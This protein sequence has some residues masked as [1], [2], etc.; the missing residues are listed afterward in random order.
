[1]F[2]NKLKICGK[3]NKEG[4][5]RTDSKVFFTLNTRINNNDKYKS[6]VYVEFNKNIWDKISPDDYNKELIIS[7]EIQARKTKNNSPFIYLKTHDV[8]LKSD[9]SKKNKKRINKQEKFNKTAIKWTH[10]F[11]EEEFEMIDIS[12]VY[13]KE[14]EHM[15]GVIN[16]YTKTHK[17]TRDRVHGKVVVKSEEDGR[18]SL[19]AGFTEF[20]HC[21]LLDLDINAYVTDLSMEEFKDKYF[22]K[23]VEEIENETENE[24]NSETDGLEEES[25]EIVDETQNNQEES[26]NIEN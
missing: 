26:V 2:S 24:T 1:M 18:Y 23:T 5:K 8:I 10:L 16:F 21:K 20:V 6:L 4:I 22:N 19:I 12:K 25:V 7:G 3:I 15:K 17:D 11:K 14:D 13:L 9:K